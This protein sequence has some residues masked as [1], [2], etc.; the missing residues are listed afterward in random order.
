MEILEFRSEA[1]R[2]ET[3]DYGTFLSRVKA[4]EVKEVEMDDDKIAFN[5]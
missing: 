4:G 1:G 5:Q 3:V 2:T